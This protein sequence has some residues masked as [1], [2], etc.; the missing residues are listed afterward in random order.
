MKYSALLLISALSTFG[1]VKAEP[2]SNGPNPVVTEPSA[3][4]TPASG[5]SCSEAANC[6][7]SEFCASESMGCSEVSG[8]CEARP[9]ICTQ[10]FQ[11]V[12]GCDGATYSDRCAASASG[13]S[14]ATAG[15]CEAKA[16]TTCG[17]IAGIVCP[18]G[19]QCVDDP[20]DSCDPKN[21]GS[22]C[23]GICT[24]APQPSASKCE[25]VR[26]EMYCEHGWKR[27]KAGCEICS[28]Q[29]R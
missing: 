4:I 3:P 27:D 14:I 23:G 21:H 7:S 15:A 28:C 29:Q 24:D 5:G 18:D 1:C 20:N 12:C 11:P 19:L 6:S 26:C 13:V 17:G 25:P 22:D 8:T 2:N 16:P 10:Q 9:E